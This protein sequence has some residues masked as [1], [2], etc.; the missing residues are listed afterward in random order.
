MSRGSVKMSCRNAVQKLDPMRAE[1]SKRFFFFFFLGK[2]QL[3]WRQ[4]TLHLRFLCTN[5]NL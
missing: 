5:E 1:L 4:H 3:P 2:P